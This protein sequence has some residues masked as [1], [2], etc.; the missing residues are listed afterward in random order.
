MVYVIHRLSTESGDNEVDFCRQLVL[1]S[2]HSLCQKWTQEGATPP[3]QDV[4]NIEVLVQCIRGGH[5]PQTQQQALSIMAA[6]APL[7]P[8]SSPLCCPLVGTCFM[9]CGLYSR[10]T[11][12]IM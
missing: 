4:V 2:L 1:S 11:F 10:S 5:S 6:I 12:C 3:K 7:Y 9:G 8:V